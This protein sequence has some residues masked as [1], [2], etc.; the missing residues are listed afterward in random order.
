MDGIGGVERRNGRY[1]MDGDEMERKRHPNISRGGLSLAMK[2]RIGSPNM[3][4]VVR[5]PTRLDIYVNCEF[6]PCGF[7]RSIRSH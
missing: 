6:G 1:Y 7:K 2:D 5:H 3:Y 4:Y